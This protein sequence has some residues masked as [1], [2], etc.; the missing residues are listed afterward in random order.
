MLE[1]NLREVGILQKK[2]ISLLVVPEYL[3][4]RHAPHRLY[5]EFHGF[6]SHF[7]IDEFDS[8]NAPECCIENFLLCDGRSALNVVTKLLPFANVLRCSFIGTR[9]DLFHLPLIQKLHYNFS[10]QS[11]LIPT[12]GEQERELSYH[13]FDI[14]FKE[15]VEEI[16]PVSGLMLTPASIEIG[17]EEVRISHFSP[18]HLPTH[19]LIRGCVRDPREL[20]LPRG[21]DVGRINLGDLLEYGQLIQG[22]RLSPL[23]SGINLYRE[24]VSREINHWASQLN[25]TTLMLTVYKATKFLIEFSGES[26]SKEWDFQTLTEKFGYC[27][28]LIFDREAG[29]RWIEVKGDCLS[30]ISVSQEAYI[31]LHNRELEF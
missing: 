11:N 6:P 24:K 5:N 21:Y 22:Q 13:S 30:E 29:D 28:Y 17:G 7:S 15:R 3:F 8:T 12:L 31:I 25:V 27:E 26:Y 18:S 19:I 16:S 1:D 9:I 23:S 4:F 10:I 14:F 20:F 2:R